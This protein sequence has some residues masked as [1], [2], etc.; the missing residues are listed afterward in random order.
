MHNAS[1][2]SLTAV[3]FFSVLP[4]LVCAIHESHV[5]LKPNRTNRASDE[6]K[7]E[8]KKRKRQN[9]ISLSKNTGGLW[10]TRRRHCVVWRIVN[11]NF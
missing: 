5:L 11:T 7:R 2:R 8:N 3:K 6:R 9:S 10:R 1:Q 4:A